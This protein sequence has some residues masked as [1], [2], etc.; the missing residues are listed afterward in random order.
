M[1]NTLPTPLAPRD[2]PDWKP[3]LRGYFWVRRHTPSNGWCICWH[4]WNQR[5]GWCVDWGIGFNDLRSAK[6]VRRFLNNKVSR[7]GSY[8]LSMSQVVE[9]LES[10][11][12]PR[13][14]EWGRW[15]T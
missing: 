10:G 15:Y 4:A 3:F 12:G 6:A 13:H 8:G 5:L 2:L 11:N 14:E 7:G 9:F 1:E